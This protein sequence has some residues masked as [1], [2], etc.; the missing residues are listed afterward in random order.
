MTTD[1]FTV[2]K[3]NLVTTTAP[4]TKLCRTCKIVRP[5]AEF[6]PSQQGRPTRDGRRRACKEWVKRT[7]QAEALP[8]GAGSF[9]NC[10][11]GRK[12]VNSDKVS[13]IPGGSWRRVVVHGVTMK[14]TEPPALTTFPAGARNMWACGEAAGRELEELVAGKEVC[15]RLAQKTKTRGPPGHALHGSAK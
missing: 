3:V 13:E 10:S 12:G 2:A 9:S 1:L 5:V 14:P 11:N 4:G 8:A 6:P 15:S 7:P